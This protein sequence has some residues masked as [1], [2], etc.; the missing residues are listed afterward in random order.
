[1]NTKDELKATDKTK[2]HAVNATGATGATGDAEDTGSK[3]PDV[4]DLIREVLSNKETVPFETHGNSMKPLFDKNA[5]AE[6]TGTSASSMG[7]G[8]VV[9]I[10]YDHRHGKYLIHRIIAIRKG[11]DGV[12][13]NTKGDS[14]PRDLQT[15]TEKDVIGKVIRIDMDT[16]YYDMNQWFW[17]Y[18]NRIAAELSH[19]SSLFVD[20]YPFIYKKK[21]FRKQMLPQRLA[22]SAL[23]RII[24]IGRHFS[25]K[26][27]KEVD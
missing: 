26:Q 24:R 7:K 25:R 13:I 14:S 27:I 6:V 3:K 4:H 21:D 2:S 15:F 22:N 23:K 18:I 5:I 11:R 20:G 17:P 12:R 8:D 9:L 1:M 19:F 16:F 10:A